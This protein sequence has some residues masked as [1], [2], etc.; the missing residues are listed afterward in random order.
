MKT[1]KDVEKEQRKQN[2]EDIERELELYHVRQ[3]IPYKLFCQ[4][5]EITEAI[6]VTNF[7]KGKQEC[8]KDELKFL[9]DLVNNNMKGE[10]DGTEAPEIKKILNRIKKIKKLNKNR[11]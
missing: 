3:A 10:E 8:L 11:R 5:L 9:E 4:L 7:N 2:K 6:A 1:E